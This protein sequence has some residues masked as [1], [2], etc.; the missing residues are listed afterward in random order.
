MS[1]RHTPAAR[2]AT[3]AARAPHNSPDRS[4]HTQS[5]RIVFTAVCAHGLI[6]CCYLQHL[7]SMA[8][9]F[10]AIYYGWR[11]R[12][13]FLLLFTALGE[14]GSHFCCYLQ[15]FESSDSTKP[16]KPL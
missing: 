11:S 9:V 13:S 15:R 8:F 4:L 5:F 2:A 1:A 7:T 3:A 12:I 10:A 14:H 16:I 6:F